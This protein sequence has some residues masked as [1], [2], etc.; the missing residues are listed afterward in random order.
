VRTMRKS[1]ARNV[2]RKVNG[3]IWGAHQ[4]KPIKGLRKRKGPPEGGVAHTDHDEGN[5]TT[6]G[7]SRV[8]DPDA[9]SANT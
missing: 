4:C 7:K 1:S 2:A 8:H 3:D 9:L 5:E 6:G